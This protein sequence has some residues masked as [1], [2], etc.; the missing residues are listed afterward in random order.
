MAGR[1]QPEGYASA[2]GRGPPDLVIMALWAAGALLVAFARFLKY[3][4]R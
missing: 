4:V 1:A 2:L 3:D